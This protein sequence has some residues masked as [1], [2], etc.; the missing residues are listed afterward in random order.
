M[1]RAEFLYNVSGLQL[2]VV[3]ISPERLEPYLQIAGGDIRYAI[4]LYEWNTKVSEALYGVTQG[5][6]VALRNAFHRALCTAFAREDWYEVASLETDQR[7]QV[8]QAKQRIRSDGRTVTPGRVVA[9][10][11]FGFWTALTGRAYAQSLWDRHLNRAFR[12]RLGRKDVAQRLKIIRFLR[13]RV[14]HHESIIGKPGSPRDLRQDFEQI[15]EATDWICSTTADWISQTCSFEVHY[16]ARPASSS[17]ST[18]A[19]GGPD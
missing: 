8:D 14:A 1:P 2:L 10:L 9:E 15:L 19:N 11:M 16:S 6:E 13:N 4:A 12:R 3:S 17:I 18:A 5:L 7:T